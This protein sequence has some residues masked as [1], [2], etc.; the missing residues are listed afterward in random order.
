VAGSIG[1]VKEALPALP[2]EL[3][4]IEGVPPAGVFWPEA[5]GEEEVW[6]AGVV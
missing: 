2:P 5:A 4:P 6:L 3:A 1:F